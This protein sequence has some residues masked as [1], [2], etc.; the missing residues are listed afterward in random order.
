MPSSKVHIKIKDAW[1]EED[2]Q[3]AIVL[4]SSTTKSYR[5]IA[6]ECRVKESTLQFRPK[7]LR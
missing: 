3:K 2:L 1:T 7:K 6:M 5:S 4:A